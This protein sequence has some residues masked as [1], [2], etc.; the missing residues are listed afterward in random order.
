VRRCHH[1]NRTCRISFLDDGA[2]PVSAW[3]CAS[4]KSSGFDMDGP[5][6]CACACVGGADSMVAGGLTRGCLA[7]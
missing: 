3:D 5:L 2:T 1:G 7:T 4:T 6:A